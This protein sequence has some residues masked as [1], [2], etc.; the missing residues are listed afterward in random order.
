MGVPVVAYRPIK[1]EIYDSYLP[2]AVS[3]EVYNENELVAL[4]R[5]IVVKES[6]QKRES[7][8]LKRDLALQTFSGLEGPLASERIVAALKR[9]EV[10]ARPMGS[11]SIHALLRELAIRG[12]PPVRSCLRRIIKGPNPL[13]EYLNQKFPSL[14]LTEVLQDVVRLQK[15]SGRFTCIDVSEIGKMMFTLTCPAASL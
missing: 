6:L 12:I 9:L 10:R 2:N 7:H 8:H 11:N 3:H 13:A 5:A 15:V 4:V 1:S 14:D